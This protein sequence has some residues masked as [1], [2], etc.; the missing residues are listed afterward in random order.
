MR[1]D[2]TPRHG[3]AQ[4]WATQLWA[5]QLPDTVLAWEWAS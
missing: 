5:T 2:V 3:A 1:V 4:L